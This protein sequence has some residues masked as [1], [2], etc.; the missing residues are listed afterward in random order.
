VWRS[1]ASSKEEGAATGSGFKA[2]SVVSVL[3]PVTT[4]TSDGLISESVSAFTPPLP[5]SLPLGFSFFNASG[6]SLSP[7]APRFEPAI[8]LRGSSLGAAADK[9]AARAMLSAFSSAAT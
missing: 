1:Q 9:G 4:A 2:K 3:M 8:G 6:A 7:P 5:P